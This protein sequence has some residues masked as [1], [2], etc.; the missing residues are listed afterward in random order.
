[1]FRRNKKLLILFSINLF[2]LSFVFVPKSF[3]V[4]VSFINFPIN[5]KDENFTVT[6]SISG[7]SLG[8]N[9][10]RVDL[11]KDGTSNYFGE[12]F[13]GSNWYSGSEGKLY[14][15]VTIDSS[16]A[17]LATVTGRL[18]DPGTDYLGTGTYK[19]KIRRYTSSGS[20]A[21]DQQTPIDIQINF[22]T[23]TPEPTLS[24]RP[25]IQSSQVPNPNKSFSPIPSLSPYV[26]LSS[27]DAG[28]EKEVLGEASESSFLNSEFETDTPKSKKREIF[29][30]SKENNI[31]KILMITGLIFILFCAI[32]FSRLYY[33]KIKKQNE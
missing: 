14:F 9:Y 18:G 3:A 5:I 17:V 19:L 10:L 24:P 7:A 11:Y 2:I 25:T 30:S 20:Q 13:N 21:S 33:K 1:M 27:E 22:S 23:P 16:K 28:L 4:S 6:A 15:P 31:P 26:E 12:T 32:L 29:L 8:Q